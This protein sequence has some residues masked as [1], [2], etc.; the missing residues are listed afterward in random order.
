LTSAI[1]A[2]ETV[3]STVMTTLLVAGS[4]YHEEPTGAD[5]ATAD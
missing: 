3:S 5:S 1:S 2:A 4:V